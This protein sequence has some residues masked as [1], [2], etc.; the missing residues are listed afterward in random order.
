LKKWLTIAGLGRVSGV[1][2]ETIR[3]YQRM[4]LLS[5]PTTCDLRSHRR[6]GPDAV[7]ELQFVRRCKAL[8]FTLKEIAALVR[9]KRT[10]R[11]TSAP[12]HAQ[13]STLGAR[14]DGK[15]RELEAQLDALRE[16]IDACP[17]DTPLA[18]CEAFARLARGEGAE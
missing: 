11:A 8:G 15:M 13:L 14:L 10:P 9:L 17:P 3:Y 16:L 6:Y 4:G 2:V 7:A 5:V 18:Q 12:F 1:G